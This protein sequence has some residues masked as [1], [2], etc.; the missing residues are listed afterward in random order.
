MKSSKYS[1]SF[2]RGHDVKHCIVVRHLCPSDELT[3]VGDGDTEEP[4]AKRPS[5][6]LKVSMTLIQEVGLLLC[7]FL[8]MAKIMIWKEGFG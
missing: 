4:V 5:R 1:F 2:S 3:V 6:R 7:D 8:T